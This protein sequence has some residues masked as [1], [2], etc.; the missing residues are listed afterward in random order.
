MTQAPKFVC[1]Y[2]CI[3]H[4]FYWNG[5]NKM[6]WNENEIITLGQTL[7]FLSIKPLLGLFFS[8]PF[9]GGGLI[10]MGGLFER[11]GLEVFNLD[12][13]MISVKN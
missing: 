7:D 13:M 8:S 6:K 2:T 12:R 10:E 1:E 9:E 11:E 4:Y 3:L 5:Q